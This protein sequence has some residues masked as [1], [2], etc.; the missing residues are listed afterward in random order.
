[1]GASGGRVRPATSG[2]SP[3]TGRRSSA[4][5]NCQWPP[6]EGRWPL[7]VAPPLSSPLPR[8]LRRLLVFLLPTLSEPEAGCEE[9]WWKT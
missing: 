4:R 3:S 8:L 1:M 7:G 5:Y 6:V 2:W 9:R